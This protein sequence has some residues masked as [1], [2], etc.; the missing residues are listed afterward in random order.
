M[1]EFVAGGGSGQGADRSSA[2]EHVNTWQAMPPDGG[3]LYL[4]TKIVTLDDA[5]CKPHQA[6]PGYYAWFQ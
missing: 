4:E 2:P 5:Y 1:S 3:E 6:K